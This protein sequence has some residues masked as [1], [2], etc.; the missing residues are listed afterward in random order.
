MGLKVEDLNVSINKQHIIKNISSIVN[1]GE[2][3]GVIGPNGSGKTTFLKS[4]YK[5]LKPESGKIHLNDKDLLN[6]PLKESAK[7]IAVVSRFN[8]SSFDFTVKELVLSG[9]TPYKK[10]FELDNNKDFEIVEDALRKTN[11]TSMRNRVFSSLSGGERQMVLL[12]RAITQETEILILDE[13]TNH[14]DINHQIQL[15]RLVKSLKKTV[16]AVLHDLNLA[17]AYCNRIY[18]IKDGEVHS[19]GTPQEVLNKQ[20]LRE[21]FGI[22]AEIVKH[23]ISDKIC[24]LPLY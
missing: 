18:V 8:D 24:V 15:L 16:F 6:M 7:K 23:P 4:I 13:P 1:D 19:H 3:V 10:S 20:M 17:A 9:R 12:A 2:F 21:V 11:M 5:I 22:N 14:L